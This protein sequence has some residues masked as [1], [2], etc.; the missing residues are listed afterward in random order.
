MRPSIVTI[1]SIMVWSLTAMVGVAFSA[2]DA[3]TVVQPASVQ[4]VITLKDGSVIHGEVIEMTVLAG[5]D[6][7]CRHDGRRLAG[8]RAVSVRISYLVGAIRRLQLE[9]AAAERGQSPT[10]RTNHPS[11]EWSD[12]DADQG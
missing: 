5:Y 12:R 1:G 11:R 10:V 8:L 2:E 9:E 4:D 7:A 3:A 6:E